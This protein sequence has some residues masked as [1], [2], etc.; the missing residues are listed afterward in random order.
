VRP[1]PSLQVSN[2]AGDPCI[3]PAN[4]GLFRF[5]PRLRVSL[6]K[7]KRRI[8]TSVS[9]SKNSVPDSGGGD[10]FDD[11]VLGPQFEPYYLHHPVSANHS[12]PIR[13]QIGPFCRD[14]RP[15]TS[16]YFGLCGRRRILLALFGACLRIQKF[17]SRRREARA[18]TS[19]HCAGNLA[20]L[21]YRNSGAW[22]TCH[23]DQ[24][25]KAAGICALRSIRAA[26]FRL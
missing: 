10:R 2:S 13:G 23:F 8:W 6:C 12:F 20:L 26:N 4:S 19:T 16:H 7:T 18:R 5:C 11:W 25:K 3:C 17:R 14:F 24:R 9:A 15:L 21:P 22:V 1:P